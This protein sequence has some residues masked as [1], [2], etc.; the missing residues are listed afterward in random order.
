MAE[1]PLVDLEVIVRYSLAIRQETA[2]AEEVLAAL[3]ESRALVLALIE[4]EAPGDTFRPPRDHERRPRV[5][6]T[7]TRRSRP[8]PAAASGQ[9]AFAPDDGVAADPESGRHGDPEMSDEVERIRQRR[10]RK[11]RQE[12]EDRQAHLE[13]A[14]SVRP[15]PRADP[16]PGP[17]TPLSAD[18]AARRRAARRRRRDVAGQDWD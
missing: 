11:A 7:A 12:A 15:A 16:E 10:L 17:P 1:V 4:A 14:R 9:V 18:E 8:E 6:G 2:P 5:A 3:D 13:Q